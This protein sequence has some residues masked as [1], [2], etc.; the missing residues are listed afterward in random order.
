MGEFDLSRIRKLDGGLL[1][2]F[3]EL[4]RCRNATEVARR[5]HVSQSA[6]T[7]SLN[8][9]RE[10]FDDPLFIRRSHG[11]E[12]TRRALELGPRIESLVDLTHE[13]LTGEGGFDPARS[14]RR[15]SLGAPEFL[16]VLIGA[17]LV[18]ALG[19][20]A[21]N[22]SIDIWHL[23]HDQA[24]ESMRRGE[25][26]LALGRFA[27]LN[28]PDLEVEALYVDRYCVVARKR[29]P[30]I[31]GTVSFQQYLDLGHVFASAF[32]EGGPGER[33]PSPLVV[34][35]TAVVPHWLTALTIVSK[36]DL[37]GSVPQRLAESQAGSLKLQVLKAP[38]PNEPWTVS[39]VRR[40]DRRD[41]GVDWL[42]EQVRACIT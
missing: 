30:L 40:T 3:R 24:L 35:T 2:T 37:L 17:R 9:L 10:L 5:L 32:S 19:R 33:I 34:P 4:L 20:S 18:Q 31:R 15:F 16:T 1:L 41:A 26:D 27:D 7:H 28:R 22:V 42:L 21:P 14:Q 29:H 6:V 13:T 25:V 12:P 8:R 36:T 39:A 38:Y 23:S 11:F